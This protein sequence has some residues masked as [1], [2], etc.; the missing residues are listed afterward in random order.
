MKALLNFVKGF[1]Q[2]ASLP[3][4]ILALYVVNLC[5]SLLLAVPLFHSLQG[6]FGASQ[7]SERMAQGFDYLWW[8]EFRDQSRG[9]A[10]TFTPALI[11]KGALLINL[12]SLLRGGFLSLPPLLLALGFLY[13][14]LR[15]LLS[16]GILSIYHANRERFYLADLL[17]GTVLYAVRFLGILFLGWIC[18][19]ACAGPL[20]GWLDSL[21]ERAAQNAASEITPFY[22]NLLVS[23]GLLFVFLCFQMVF[24]YARISSVAQDQH[25]V[26][27]AALT[28]FRFVFRHPGSTLGLFGLLFLLQVCVTIVYVLLRSLIPQS[29]LLGVFSAFL[30]LQLF[31]FIL[32]WIRCWLYS[33]QMHLFRFLQ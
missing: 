2:S 27:R 30:L 29:G 11:G 18:L 4:M 21:V 9:L 15:S 6:S 14:I 22:L 24:D 25:N 31:I 8:E 28:G 13:L 12:E 33:S 1:S 26:L 32:I 19:I 17:Q 10:G 5:L 16:G 7:V 20:S 23:A 3:K